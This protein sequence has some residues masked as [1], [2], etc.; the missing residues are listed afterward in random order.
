[1]VTRTDCLSGA[2]ESI[3]TILFAEQVHL[4]EQ[5]LDPRAHILAFA[6]QRVHF[7]AQP[8]RLG[9]RVRGLAHRRLFLFLEA[10]NQLDGLYDAF[11]EARQ[12][13]QFVFARHERHAVFGA[14]RACSTSFEKAAASVVAMSESTLRLSSMPAFFRPLMN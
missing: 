3:P 9:A 1:M 11:L 7:F 14:A 8:G 4:P 2:P 6:P 10:C 12:R 5:F 13:I